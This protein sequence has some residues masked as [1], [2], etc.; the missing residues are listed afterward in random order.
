MEQTLKIEQS[1]GQNWSAV[2][3]VSLVT[4]RNTFKYGLFESRFDNLIA[5]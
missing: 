2:G 4:V 5:L 1:D 3:V